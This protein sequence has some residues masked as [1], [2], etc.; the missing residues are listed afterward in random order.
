MDIW[1]IPEEQVYEELGTSP[2]G[3]TEDEAFARSQQYGH[4]TLPPKVG[5]PIIFRFFDQF[6]NLFAI[7][8][9]VGAL[10]TFIAAM[11]VSYTHLRAHETRHDLV[12]RLLLE[13]K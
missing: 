5:R 8:L 12:C 11:P 3:L 10:C 2:K 1:A 7:M 13:K 4:N 9:E 6:T